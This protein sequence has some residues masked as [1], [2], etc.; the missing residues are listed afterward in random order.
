MSSRAAFLVT[1][2]LLAIGV[3]S[4]V[5][6]FV[7]NK[8]S[9]SGSALKAIQEEETL[10]REENAMLR[11]SITDAFSLTKIASKASELGFIRDHSPLV[12]TSGQSFALR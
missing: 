9:T 3:L 10:L 11:A 2:I 7:S 8:L 12:L 1:V 6:L 5:Q 4:A